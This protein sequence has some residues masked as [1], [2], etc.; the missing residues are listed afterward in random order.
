MDRPTSEYE[1]FRAEH[2]NRLQQ[3]TERLETDPTALFVYHTARNKK[4]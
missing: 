1:L 2:L 4:P 3:E